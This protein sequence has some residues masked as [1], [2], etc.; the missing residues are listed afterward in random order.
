MTR[1]L[2]DTAIDPPGILCSLIKSVIIESNLCS[3]PSASSLDSHKSIVH[4][5]KNPA[6]MSIYLLLQVMMHQLYYNYSCTRKSKESIDL[7]DR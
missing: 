1:P 5:E 3:D 4:C 7:S 2:Y 6:G